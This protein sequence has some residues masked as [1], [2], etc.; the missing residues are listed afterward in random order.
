MD[1]K[2]KQPIQIGS[3]VVYILSDKNTTVVPAIVLEE[4]T[5]RTINGDS[6]TY[7]VGIGQ[8]ASKV[9]DLS[10]VDGEIFFSLREVEETLKER[11]NVFCRKICE[12][13]NTNA[14]K[15]YGISSDEFN[16]QT[17]NTERV[18]AADLL[19]QATQHSNE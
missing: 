4:L 16:Q 19:T 6:I 7:K 3:S 17:D 5:V 12:L 10:K 8:N 9:I 1:I 11:L 14:M 18:D 15:W 2:K 13:A